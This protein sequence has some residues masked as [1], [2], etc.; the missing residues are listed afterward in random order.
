M[1]EYCFTEALNEIDLSG[2]KKTLHRLTVKRWNSIKGAGVN[3]YVKMSKTRD[4]LLLKGYEP[5]LIAHEIKALAEKQKGA[6]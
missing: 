4:Y 1:S 2:Y 6:G 3:I 5:G